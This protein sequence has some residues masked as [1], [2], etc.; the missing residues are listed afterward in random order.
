MDNYIILLTILGLATLAV[1]WL[2]SLV[3]RYALSYPALFV[4]FGILLYS[5]PFNLPDPNPLHNRTIATRLT[6]LCVI[7]SLMG[8]G[9]KIDQPFS[10]RGWTIPLRLVLVTMILTIASFSWLGWWAL[11]LSPAAAALLAAAMAPTDP[12]LAGDVQVSGPGEGG[13]DTVRF[14]LTGEAGMNDG[15]AFPFVY[16]AMALLPAATP[17]GQR[18]LDWLLEDLLYKI[19]A[20]VAVGW[21]AGRLLSLLVFGLPSKLRIRK[22]GYGFVSLAVTLLTYGITEIAHGYG[23]LAVFIAAIVLRKHERSHEY[24]QEMHDFSDQIERLLIVVILI[25]FGGALVNGLFKTL[26]W[27]GALVGLALLFIIRPLSGM[28]ALFRTRSSM[29]ERWV[30]SFF[31]IRGIGSLYYLAF[32]IDEDVFDNVEELWAIA[33]FIVLV[34]IVM[35]GML[36]TPVMNWLD[37]RYDRIRRRKHPETSVE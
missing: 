12:V 22:S 4:A 36:A 3:S 30:I 16:F 27:Q 33:G 26:T 5:L 20:A 7:V 9:L 8:T 19:A 2:P 1:A 15:L 17:L 6:E 35:H 21:L 18:L 13:E 24:H 25:L 10:F 23:F 29:A 11:G 31:G 32:A 37:K 34:S 14:S 28:M